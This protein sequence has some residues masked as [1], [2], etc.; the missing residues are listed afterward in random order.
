MNTQTPIYLAYD[1]PLLGALW[2]MFVFFLWIMWFTLLFRVI[3]DV[4]RDDRLSGWAKAGWLVFCTLVPFLGV[5]VYVMVRGKDMGSR[6]WA[7]ARAQQEEF[8]EYIRAAAVASGD[9]PSKADEL[10]KLSE[11]RAKGDITDEEF[12]RAKELVLSGHGTAGAGSSG[13]GA[14]GTR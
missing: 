7:R 10:A 6:E 9:R 3:L 11:V 12:S 14:R 5:F 1:F 2:T 13:D 8:H 4:F